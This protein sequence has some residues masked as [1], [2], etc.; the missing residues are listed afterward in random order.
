MA[1]DKII[2]GSVVV[3]LVYILLALVFYLVA[4][5]ELS[6]RTD[7]TNMVSMLDSTGELE[8]GKEV[9]Q[10]FAVDGDELR[11]ITL[12]TATYDRINTASLQISVV[13]MNGNVQGSLQTPMSGLNNGLS[14][15]NFAEPVIIEPGE[16]YDLVFST[17][18]GVFGNTIALMYGNSIQLRQAVVPLEIKPDEQIRVN[19][20]VLPGKLCVQ[21]DFGKRL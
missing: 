12:V 5:N 1:K 3:L 17:P 8:V 19:D 20:T 7:Q 4:G 14:E 11:S 18:D 10:R 21:L 16:A 6:Y 2:K 9:R 15:L 13:D